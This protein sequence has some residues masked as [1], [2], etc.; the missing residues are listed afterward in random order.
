VTELAPPAGPKPI[1][2][3]DVYRLIGALYLEIETLRRQNAYL[4]EQLAAVKDSA[5]A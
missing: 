3:E 2:I 4:T 1:M 5:P